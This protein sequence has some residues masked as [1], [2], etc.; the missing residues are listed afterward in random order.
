MC[1]QIYP[2]KN[3]KE[4]LVMKIV[5]LLVSIYFLVHSLV[6]NAQ[7]I[8]ISSVTIHPFDSIPVY[9]GNSKVPNVAQL[10]IQASLGSESPNPELVYLLLV[11]VST[12]KEFTPS[13]ATLNILDSDKDYQIKKVGNQFYYHRKIAFNSGLV[14]GMNNSVRVEMAIVDPK[15]I[16]N[17]KGVYKDIRW[18]KDSKTTNIDLEL[19]L[20]YRDSVNYYTSLVDFDHNFEIVKNKDGFS[21][22]VIAG[23]KSEYMR[24]RLSAIGYPVTQSLPIPKNEDILLMGA[25]S[26]L[27]PYR[28]YTVNTQDGWIHTVVK[29]ISPMRIMT[30]S[31]SGS[32][33]TH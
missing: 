7:S 2:Y 24:L 29:P 22:P 9:S 16:D 8:E 11:H 21:W 15:N 26:S 33:S 32:F 6:L 4:I 19:D 5:K 12:Q 3:D 10:E 23:P 25:H 31:F 30:G 28:I 13:L 14:P 1:T 20:K 18:L 17:D 27:Q